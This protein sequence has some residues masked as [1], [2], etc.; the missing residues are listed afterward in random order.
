[1]MVLTFIAILV[2]TIG[3]PNFFE[4]QFRASVSR[5][6]SELV[7]LKMAIEAYRADQR[8][9]P[10]NETPGQA[11]PSDLVVLTTPVPYMTR[12]PYDFFTTVE[13][14]PV[15]QE[16]PRPPAYYRYFNA[17]QASPE[18]GLTV[19]GPKTYFG[20]GHIA[21]LLW[22]SGPGE[23]FQAEAKAERATRISPQA[24]AFLLPYDPTNG[25]MSRGDIYER[26]P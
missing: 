18:T 14:R 25:T 6:R 1:M 11:G 17:V 21:A 24:E 3:V 26:L 8:A 15:R 23:A 19:A 16:H 20:A 2:A 9:Y 13:A 7:V 5:T 10:P 12:L 4:A 22:G